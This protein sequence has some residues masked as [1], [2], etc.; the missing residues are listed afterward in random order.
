MI[1]RYAPRGIGHFYTRAKYGLLTHAGVDYVITPRGVRFDNDGPYLTQ[2]E[3]DVL[4]AQMYKTPYPPLPGRGQRH[5]QGVLADNMQ[6][7]FVDGGAG[8]YRG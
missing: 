4:A 5:W 7:A 2:L 8:V 6:R 3:S 1:D